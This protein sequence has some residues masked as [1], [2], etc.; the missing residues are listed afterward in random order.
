MIFVTVGKVKLLGHT[1]YMIA[2]KKAHQQLID[3]F[4]TG[5]KLTYKK[6]ESI[7]HAGDEPHGIYYITEGYVKA[8]AITKYGEENLLIIRQKND[9]FPLIWAF[10]GLHRDITYQAMSDATLYRVAKSDFLEYLQKNEHVITVML[11]MAIEAYRLHSERVNSLEYRTVRERIASF[12]LTH[13][14]RF[15]IK[16]KDGLVITAPIRRQDIA[17]SINASRETTSR[18]LSYLASQKIICL[19]EKQI[20]ITNLKKLQ[21]L[22]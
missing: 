18:E 3:F 16:S 21:D 15:G 13:A 6:G 17:A 20:E 10:T 12:L 8:Y 5:S 14:D 22:L 1:Y 7:V 19:S 4:K 11:D 9:V 2:D